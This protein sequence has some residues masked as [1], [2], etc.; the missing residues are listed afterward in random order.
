MLRGGVVGD[1]IQEDPESLL[2]GLC[3]Q[4]LRFLHRP[5]SGIDGPIVGDV[6]SA[7]VEGRD[8]PGVDP[9]CVHAERTDVTE[10]R[11]KTGDVAGAVTVAVGERAQV[12]LIDDR[13]APPGRLWSHRTIMTAGRRA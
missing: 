6:V 1:E 13:L 7:V 9:D 5:K 4:R 3:D 11:A 10:A 2:P 12:D 8:V